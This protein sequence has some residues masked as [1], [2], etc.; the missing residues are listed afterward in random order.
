MAWIIAREAGSVDY[1]NG[2]TNSAKEYYAHAM[3]IGFITAPKWV[4]NWKEAELFLHEKAAMYRAQKLN[5]ECV[6]EKV[7]V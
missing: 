4:R 5:C 1:G 2:E 6:I 3:K 7:D